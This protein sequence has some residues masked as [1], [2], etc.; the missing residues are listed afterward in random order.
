MT[1]LPDKIKQRRYNLIK[2][3]L[4][5]VVA[6]LTDPNI[7]EDGKC[8]AH[9]K[10][11]GSPNAC[12]PVDWIIVVLNCAELYPVPAPESCRHSVGE[13]YKLLKTANANF[14]QGWRFEAK[15]ARR[16]TEPIFCTGCN[17]FAATMKEIQAAYAS[18]PFVTLTP[19]QTAR[20]EKQRKMCGLPSVQ[21]KKEKKARDRARGQARGGRR[22]FPPET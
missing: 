15:L 21:E 22:R 3:M 8:D 20:M 9:R 1:L 5:P 12:D 10:T 11:P 16:D 17:P 4:D 7:A 14:S 6:F 19:S 13:L 18:G 2:A